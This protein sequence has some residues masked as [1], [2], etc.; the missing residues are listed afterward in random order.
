M[1]GLKRSKAAGSYGWSYVWG[2]DQRV[3]SE[4]YKEN[5]DLIKFDG[6]NRPPDA[7]VNG[8]RGRANRWIYK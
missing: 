2:R 8:I 1:P 5:Y 7:V 3:L 6:I 4:R